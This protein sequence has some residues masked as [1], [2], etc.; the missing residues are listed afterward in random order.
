VR[1]VALATFILLLGV[2]A[3]VLLA[4]SLEVRRTEPPTGPRMTA[5]PVRRPVAPPQEPPEEDRRV[6]FQ[7]RGPSALGF[8]ERPFPFLE[9]EDERGSVSVGTVI[10]GYLV[11]AAELAVPGQHYGI[12]PVQLL[13]GLRFTTDEMADLL[14][15]AAEQVAEAFPG[16]TL[17]LGNLS[18][19]DGGDIAWSVSHNSGRD[20]DVAFYFVDANGQPI[21]PPNLMRVGREL[22]FVHDEVVYHFD[23][24]RNWALVKALLTD[25]HVQVQFLFIANF[26]KQALLRYA[27]ENGEPAGLLARAEAVMSQPGR[28]NPHDDHLHV[29]LYCSRADATAGCLNTGRLHGWIDAYAEARPRRIREVREFLEHAEP[30][31][32]ARAIERL[33]ILDSREDATRFVP[34]LRDDSPRVRAA[35]ARGLEW[36]RTATA[37]PALVEAFASETDGEVLLALIDALGALDA[38]A[39]DTYLAQHLGDPMPVVVR[40][41]EID[42]RA[43]IVDALTDGAETGL[44]PLLVG[45]L[46]SDDSYLRARAVWALARLTNQRLQG[47]WEDARLDAESREAGVRRWHEWLEA[48]AAQPRVAWLAE[49][50][51]ADGRPVLVDGGLD[52]AALVAA[53][54]SRHDHVRYNA[55]QALMG[56][57]R[58]RPPS[59]TW[60]TSD[61][62]WYWRDAVGPAP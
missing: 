6:H 13:R 24:P 56:L 55:Q 9:D 35:A 15:R 39:A 60:P 42:L 49:G 26:L 18:R 22:F 28:S 47:D 59:L 19:R 40:G 41:T 21:A 20:A 61:A 45:L 10:D 27:V 34:L 14:R 62:L 23:V 43:V 51:A 11:N 5:E 16:S 57:L 17:W 52:R 4:R 2:T 38:A 50:Y 48:R 1:R 32:R 25:E 53:V 12:L 7:R 44:A 8:V 36:A 31:Q 33:A 37:L 58:R 54:A 30:E 3:L 46:G 29:R